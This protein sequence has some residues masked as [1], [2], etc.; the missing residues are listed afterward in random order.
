VQEIFYSLDSALKKY[1][2]NDCFCNPKISEL[3]PC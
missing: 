1:Y 3:G 2:F